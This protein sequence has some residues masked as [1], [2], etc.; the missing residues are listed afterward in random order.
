MKNHTDK[1]GFVLNVEKV[2]G[3]SFIVRGIG[4]IAIDSIF[5]PEEIIGMYPNE[6]EA[7]RF[8]SGRIINDRDPFEAI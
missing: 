7:L 8:A 3:T 2:V 6:N 5:I 1:W 4:R